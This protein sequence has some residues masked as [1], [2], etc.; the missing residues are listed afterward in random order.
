MGKLSRKMTSQQQEKFVLLFNTAHSVAMYNWSLKDFKHLCELQARNGLLIGDN[1]HNSVGASKFIN[2]IAE[3]QRQDTM[4]C[5]REARFFS[6]RADGSTDRS[7]AEQEAV[8]VRYVVNGEPINKFVGLEEVEHANASGV[9]DAI[10]ICLSK[11]VGI[12]VDTLKEKLVNMN[13]DGAAVNLG[14]YNGVGT[15]QQRR[16]TSQ[17]TVTHCVNHNL[18]LALMD[19]RKEEPY[20][21]IFEKTLKVFTH[22]NYILLSVLLLSALLFSYMYLLTYISYFSYLLLIYYL[23]FTNTS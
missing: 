11:R 15:L 16:S 12:L 20:L 14:I 13:L 1:Y 18:E 22:T 21:S 10:D 4:R 7:I 9:L 17:V 6:I 2:S 3:V 5:L 8:Y 19:M 23:I